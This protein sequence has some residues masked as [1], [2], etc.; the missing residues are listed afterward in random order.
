LTYRKYAPLPADHPSIGDPCGLCEVPFKEGD[1]T[2]LIPMESREAPARGWH[3]AE[4][5]LVHWACAKGEE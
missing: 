3:A 2:T 4:A 1:E 5:M